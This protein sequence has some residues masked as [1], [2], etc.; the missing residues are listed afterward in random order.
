[1][2]SKTEN[3]SKLMRICWNFEHSSNDGQIR[4]KQIQSHQSHL[5]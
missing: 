5:A 1:M 4:K 2:T 3:D